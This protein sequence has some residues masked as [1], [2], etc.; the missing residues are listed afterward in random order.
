MV[1]DDDINHE[2][3]ALGNTRKQELRLPLKNDRGL[4]DQ[5]LRDAIANSL[6]DRD[7]ISIFI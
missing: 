1:L 7:L 5:N 4:Q 6:G 3:A 2:I